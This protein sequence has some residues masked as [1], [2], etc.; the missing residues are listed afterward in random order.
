[1]KKLMGNISKADLNLS[2]ALPRAAAGAINSCRRLSTA[3]S[4]LLRMATV[5]VCII[6]RGQYRNYR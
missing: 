6:P 3:L 2:Q 5:L 1:M 4:Q